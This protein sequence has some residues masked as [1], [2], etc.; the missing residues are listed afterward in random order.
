MSLWTCILEICQKTN[1]HHMLSVYWAWA[2]KNYFGCRQIFL[3]PWAD[4]GLCPPAS[5][6]RLCPGTTGVI[7]RSLQ[8]SPAV[9]T[10]SL[11]IPYVFVVR[12]ENRIYIVHIPCW[13]RLKYIHVCMLS[14]LT[15]N[16]KNFQTERL[17]PC[18]SVLDPP[19]TRPVSCRWCE[20]PPSI[21]LDHA[22]TCC[23]YINW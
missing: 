3:Y 5:L 13:P 15:K 1:I 6:Q 14:K 22:T 16:N 10:C 2:L 11:H 9:R 18:A 23:E 8:N 19:L 17:T 20:L 4:G 21:D 7:L 12:V